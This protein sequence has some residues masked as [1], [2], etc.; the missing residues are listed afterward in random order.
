MYFRDDPAAT[1]S[2]R[3]FD[4]KEFAADHLTIMMEGKREYRWEAVR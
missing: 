1:A 4:I 2:E 3:F